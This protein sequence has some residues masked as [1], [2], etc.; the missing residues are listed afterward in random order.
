MFW[1]LLP[2]ISGVV[3]VT[4]S[5]YLPSLFFCKKNFWPS[6]PFPSRELSSDCRGFDIPPPNT[7]RFVTTLVA[8]FL[9]LISPA[10]LSIGYCLAVSVQPTLSPFGI[11]VTHFLNHFRNQVLGG[12]C[13]SP[14]AGVDN[15]I[16]PY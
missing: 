10:H 12:F 3:I 14:T 13:F 16:V 8:P 5:R 2:T 4:G 11:R 9:W 7:V 6:F 15:F 1:L